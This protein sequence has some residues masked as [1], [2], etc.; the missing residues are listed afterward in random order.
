[1]GCKSCSFWSPSF[2]RAET[3]RGYPI[4]WRG[5]AI[6]TAMT[7]SFRS[8]RFAQGGRYDGDES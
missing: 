5:Y 1:M 6:M 3:S 8:A 2:R 7:T 4:R